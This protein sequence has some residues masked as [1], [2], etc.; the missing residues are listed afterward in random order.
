MDYDLGIFDRE[1]NKVEPVG[2]NPF[3]PKVLP[4]LPE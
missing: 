2:E 3:A 1:L 4:M